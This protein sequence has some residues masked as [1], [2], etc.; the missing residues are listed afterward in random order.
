MIADTATNELPARIVQ[1]FKD[2]YHVI[3]H[4]TQARF[5]SFLLLYQSYPAY[6]LPSALQ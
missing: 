3:E 1:N 4:E 2:F 5:I 6:R